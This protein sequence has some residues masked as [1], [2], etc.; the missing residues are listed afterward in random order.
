MD[1]I[2]DKAMLAYLNISLPSQTRTDKRASADVEHDNEA[3]AGR[4]R[5][6]KRL[7]SKQAI[8][9]VIAAAQRVRL[10]HYKLTLSWDDTGARLLPLTCLLDYTEKMQKAIAEYS[11]YVSEF[12]NNYTEQLEVERERLG[13]LFN[14]NDYPVNPGAT[15]GAVYRL[16]A[17]PSD[18]KVFGWDDDLAQEISN[19]AQLELRQGVVRAM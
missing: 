13:K 17:V 9:P 1:S 11:E 6:V 5:V 18:F 14:A 3:H 10:L 8:G 15:C 12:S 16:R 7:F 2:Q 19:Q 4:A